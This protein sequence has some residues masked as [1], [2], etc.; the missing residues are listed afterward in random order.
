M[1]SNYQYSLLSK[2]VLC[3]V[4]MSYRKHFSTEDFLFS[5]GMIEAYR[6]DSAVAITPRVIISSELLDLVKIEIE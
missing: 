1:I 5:N 3:R 2:G 4:G 6:L